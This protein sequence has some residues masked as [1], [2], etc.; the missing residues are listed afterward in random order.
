[1][2]QKIGILTATMTVLAVPAHAQRDFSEV[3]IISTDLGAGIFMLEGAGGNI[4]LSVGEDGAFII[5]DQ[6]APLSDKILAAIRTQTDEP[7]GFLINTHFHGDHAGGNEPFN[8]AGAMIVAHERVRAR[9]AAGSDIK[10][11]ETPPAPEGALPAITFDRSVTFFRNGQE[12]H[13]FHLP[14]SHTDGDA[15]VHFRTANAVHTGD[16]FFNTG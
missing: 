4:G 1:M 14:A 7:L 13:V 15:V 10:G 12:I 11:R 5:D 8:A 16:L 6:F 9:L 3:E 2:H